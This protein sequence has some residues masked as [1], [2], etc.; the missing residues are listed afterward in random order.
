MVISTR[1]PSLDPGIQQLLCPAQVGDEGQILLGRD[2]P[3]DGAGFSVFARDDV[4][5]ADLHLVLGGESLLGRLCG[6]L[7]LFEREGVLAEVDVLLGE[8]LLGEEIPMRCSACST[9]IR[10]G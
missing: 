5:D 8:E 2:P 1:Y 10:M 6:E 3:N 9:L 7:Q 4:G